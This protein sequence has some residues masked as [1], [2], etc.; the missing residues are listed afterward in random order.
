MPKKNTERTAGY[1][2]G[3]AN[4][5]PPRRKPTPPPS[6]FNEQSTE[7]AAGKPVKGSGHR[8]GLNTAEWGP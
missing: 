1:P 5:G 4:M 2:G 3:R 6:P 7:D 8:S